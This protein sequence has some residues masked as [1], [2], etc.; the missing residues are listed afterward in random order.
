MG[1]PSEGPRSGGWATEVFAPGNGT[2]WMMLGMLLIG[3]RIALAQWWRLRQ[4]IN[5][6]SWRILA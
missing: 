1:M 6:A 4:R 3:V 2:V 5:R